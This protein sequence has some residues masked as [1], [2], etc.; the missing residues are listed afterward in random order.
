MKVTVHLYT[1]S[2]PIVFTDVINAYQK[3]DLYCVF[4]RIPVGDYVNGRYNT[5]QEQV[6]KFPLQHIFRIIEE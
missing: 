3:G 4:T 2:Q 5:N 1:Q 6:V